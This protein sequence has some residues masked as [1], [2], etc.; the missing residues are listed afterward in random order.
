MKHSLSF[1]FVLLLLFTSAVTR[2]DNHPVGSKVTLTATADGSLPITFVWK[3]DGNALGADGPTNGEGVTVTAN[4]LVIAAATVANSGSYT[5]TATNEVGSATSDPLVLN[6]LAPPSKPIITKQIVSVTVLKKA[7]VLFAVEALGQELRYNW[8]KGN[9]KYYGETTPTLALP[10]V[11]PSDA[12]TYT[13]VV[14]NPAGS[15]SSSARLTVR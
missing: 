13:V 11:N 6:F 14:S 10:R 4:S 3:K 5:V 7:N 9:T 15:A 2:A 12:G 8:W 1:L